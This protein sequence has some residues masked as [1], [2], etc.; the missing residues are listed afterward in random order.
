VNGVEVPVFGQPKEGNFAVFFGDKWTTNFL[1]EK[2]FIYRLDPSKTPKALDLCPT[3]SAKTLLGIYHLDGD[4]LKIC[5][6]QRGKQERPATFANYW[7]PES[8]TCLIVLKRQPAARDA[9]D[10][11]VRRTSASWAD[12][13]FTQR[14]KDFGTCKPGEKLRHRFEMM[15]CWSVPLDISVSRVSSVCVTYS[16]SHKT[17]QPRETGYLEVTM[18][19]TVFT[20]EKSVDINVRV[21]PTYTSVATLTIRANVSVPKEKQP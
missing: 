20:G 18:D 6:C 5:F 12:K 17:L 19:T 15:N 10:A 3:D 14:S 8:Y 13:L 16:L 4:D 1:E 11:G 21:G 2:E 7:K 9:G